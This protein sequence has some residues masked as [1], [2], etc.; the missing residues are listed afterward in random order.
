MIACSHSK[1]APQEQAWTV[2]LIARANHREY[3]D[4]SDMYIIIVHIL[5]YC[6]KE[7]EGARVQVQVWERNL[8]M[9]PD[10]NQWLGT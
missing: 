6:E 1:S 7:R 9:L 3:A 8:T 10:M 4:T 2:V 5:E